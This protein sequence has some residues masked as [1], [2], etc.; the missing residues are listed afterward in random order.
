VSEILTGWS[1]LVGL[2]APPAAT[3]RRRA[4]ASLVGTQDHGIMML[5]GL[6]TTPSCKRSPL[7]GRVRLR[8]SVEQFAELNVNGFKRWLNI[9]PFVDLLCHQSALVRLG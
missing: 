2:F 9:W 7:K 8:I 6:M 1:G 4:S 3:N 5:A